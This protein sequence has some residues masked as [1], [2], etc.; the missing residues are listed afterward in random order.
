MEF[1]LEYHKAS[2]K[3]KHRHARARFADSGNAS[4]EI[5]LQFERYLV[6]ERDR[7]IDE[8]FANNGIFSNN[9]TKRSRLS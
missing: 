2:V 1:S 6:R 7:Q 4:H 5:H 8:T 3:N 9:R